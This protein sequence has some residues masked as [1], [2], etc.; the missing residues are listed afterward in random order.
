MVS[1]TLPFVLLESVCVPSVVVFD[2]FVELGTVIL[3]SPVVVSDICVCPVLFVV[4]V[5]LETV[6]TSSPVVV[7]ERVGG[8]ELSDMSVEVVNSPKN[9]YRY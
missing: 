5:E 8:P 4:S 2:A 1:I 9:N 3:D 7:P 6:F